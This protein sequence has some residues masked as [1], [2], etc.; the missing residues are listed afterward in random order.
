MVDPLLDEQN[1]RNLS[2][3]L[4][5][6]ITLLAF[7]V[8]NVVT[9][10]C[11]SLEPC[12]HCSLTDPPGSSDGSSCDLAFGQDTFHVTCLAGCERCY[13]PA[14]T[15]AR[16][17]CLYKP[18][19]GTTPRCWT[20]NNVNRLVACNDDDCETCDGAPGAS[21]GASSTQCANLP[22]CATASCS[23]AYNRTNGF[24]LVRPI[25]EPAIN[26]PC[27]TLSN[28]FQLAP[29]STLMVCRS[30]GCLP[31]PDQPPKCSVSTTCGDC[32][33]NTARQCQWCAG[34]QH[35]SHLFL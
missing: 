5:I 6:I 1:L 2:T 15:A 33:Q 13:A 32:V 29:A 25:C 4:F 35:S 26:S 7:Y 20:R 27:K 23:P 16:R 21:V 30:N 18:N 22:E 10:D 31:C 8:V 28:A 19:I 17:I 34:K 3:M 12:H 9:I 14:S 24:D 11:S